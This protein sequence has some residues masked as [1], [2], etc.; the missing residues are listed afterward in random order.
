MLKSVCVLTFVMSMFILAASPRKK[1]S[2][3]KIKEHWPER[4]TN[5]SLRGRSL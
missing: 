2:K 4:C 3:L 1:N 5:R